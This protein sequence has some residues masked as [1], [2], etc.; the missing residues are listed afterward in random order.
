VVL[1][2]PGMR[3]DMIYTRLLSA[4]PAVA[5]LAWF[6]GAFRISFRNVAAYLIYAAFPH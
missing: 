5:F 6:D 4:I 2:Y 1:S 3:K